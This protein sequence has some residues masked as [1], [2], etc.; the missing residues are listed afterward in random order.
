MNRRKFLSSAGLI[1][2][3]PAIVRAESLMKIWVP[4]EPVWIGVDFARMHESVSR[5]VTLGQLKSMGLISLAHPHAH[6]GDML[7]F[8]SRYS[9]GD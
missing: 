8:E 6:E 1:L 3:A 5:Y 2:G 9:V 4:L 7:V